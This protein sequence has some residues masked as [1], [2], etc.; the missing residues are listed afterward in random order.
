[1]RKMDIRMDMIKK[2]TD[3]DSE[4]DDNSIDHEGLK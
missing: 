1:M 3:S 2:Y 4:D